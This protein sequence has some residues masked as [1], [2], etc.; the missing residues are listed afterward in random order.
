M[1]DNPATLTPKS[2]HSVKPRSKRRV[3]LRRVV[4]FFAVLAVLIGIT[5]LSG[6]AFMLGRSITAPT[7][8]EARIEARLADALPD[9][10]IKFDSL[11][12]LVETTGEPRVRLRG[13]TV[14][15]LQGTEIISFSEAKTSLSM[16]ALLSRQLQPSTIELTGVFATLQRSV[17]GRVSLS[18]GTGGGSP[19][20]Q[21]ANLH[22]LIKE[23]ET[24]L[25]LPALSALKSVQLR[26]LTLNYIDLRAERRWTVDGGRL[27]LNREGKQVDL[28]A[29]LAI[30][31]GGAGAAILTANFASEIGAPEAEFGISFDEVSASDIAAQGPAFAWLDV[32][33][34]PISGAVRSGI[35]PD[36]KLTPLNASLHI[37]A[38]ALQP[39]DATKPIPFDGARSYF[40][41]DASAGEL[42]FD[43]LSINSQWVSGRAEGKAQLK[44]ENGKLSNLIGQIALSDISANPGDLYPEPLAL[45]GG[46]LDYQIKFNPFRFE[47]GR[48]MVTDQGQVL[49]S[50]GHL[51]ATPQGWDMA[52]DASID[53]IT[54]ARLLTLWPEA[55]KPKTRN[56]VVDNVQAADLSNLQLALRLAPGQAIRSFASFDFAKADVRF[57]KTMPPIMSGKGHASFLDNRFVVA[58]DSG[59]VTAPQG[60]TVQ[61][62]GSSF[63]L[64]D[65]TVKGGT[66]AVT[67][68]RARSQITAATALL[69]LPPLSIMDKAGIAV[70]VAQGRAEMTGT[71][72]FPLKKGTKPGDVVFDVTGDL[73]A[74]STDT[75][76]KGRDLRADKM[77]LTASNESL[78]IGGAGR[79]DGVSFEG[80]WQQ[81]IGAGSSK[82]QLRGAA[83]LNQAAL[84]AFGIAL[85]PGTL[86]GQGR[87]TL[88]LQFEKGQAPRFALSSDL[89]G[90]RLSVPQVGWSKP[91]A[92]KGSLA[93][94][95]RLG[96]TPK[97][98]KITLD[99]PGLSATGA[100]TLKPGGALDRV[101]FDRLR[102]GGWLDVPVDLVG[103]GAG[104]SPQVMVHG[105]SLDMRR[106]EFGS[107][108]ASGT[109]SGASAAPPMQ[110]RL[111]KLQ[112]TDTIALT[113][114]HGTF[115][116]ARGLDGTFQAR[117]NNQAPIVG[118]ISPQGGRSAVRVQ[119][120]DAGAVLRAADVLKQGVGGALTLTLLPVGSGGAFDGRLEI[121]NTRIK[122]APSIAA[123][124]NAISVVGLLEQMDGEGIYFDTVE[125]DFRLTPNRI[126]V[127]KA[128]AVGASMG[129]SIDGV[130]A[131][132]TG[133][134]A[135]Q[136]V[137]SPVYL[138]NGI[139]AVLT[140]KGEGLIG[141]NY[142]LSGNAKD[143]QVSV[144]PLSALTPGMFRDLFR[145]PP[146]DLP[147][148][149]GITGSTL[150]NPEPEPQNR[151]EQRPE[152][153]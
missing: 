40:S 41:Y 46:E 104:R 27:S 21:S 129:I 138:L 90:L 68:L 77:A 121:A 65:V 131:T 103:R 32:L 95:G 118:R 14:E 119:A 13:I 56:W 125:A 28:A 64:P 106:A 99:A 31:G 4:M 58:L 69:N 135:M 86:N 37:G 117:L 94:S 54:P 145:A 61:L 151:V 91:A 7:W 60:G 76:V 1:S 149:E 35:G 109:A 70:D 87:G 50:A 53:G 112:I 23:F 102:V 9:L 133:N 128:S 120:D 33:R 66:P 72:A 5:L 113:S 147:A 30:L 10:R 29:D 132:D 51:F 92:A 19:F 89:R 144:N 18:G 88:D 24:A 126:T 25:E 20:R 15:S 101:R 130:Y 36:G 98:D 96:A 75:L 84:D 124:L 6:A 111:D 108:G 82:S 97:V 42:Q 105:G 11:D 73:L 79:I 139:G 93:V 85:P 44:V 140:R 123:L 153:R 38:G 12:L 81:P 122:D 55:L 134:I 142:T 110:L 137:I 22:G 17:D 115:N 2:K 43:E 80:A 150:P 47:L 63:I 100:V 62:A 34:A 49:R 78:S 146:P 48:M 59:Q 16:P 152:G 57:L 39:E 148:V 114:M 136:G 71:L 45:E 52:V 74:L 116:T 8:I 67:R 141:F 3:W 83:V 26:A 107:A 143:P 127:A